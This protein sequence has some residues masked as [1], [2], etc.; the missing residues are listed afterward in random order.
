EEPTQYKIIKVG[1]LS[2]NTVRKG[3]EGLRKKGIIK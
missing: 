3:I 1:G 2:K